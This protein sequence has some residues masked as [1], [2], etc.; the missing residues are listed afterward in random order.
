MYMLCSFKKKKKIFVYRA[1]PLTPPPPSLV[2]FL[3]ILIIYFTFIV[4]LVTLDIILSNLCIYTYVA[5]I[6]LENIYI[7]RRYTYTYI[8]VYTNRKKNKIVLYLHNIKHY[9]K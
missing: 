2:L 9:D 1:H 3:Y 5:R 7:N 6:I 8:F 4:Y